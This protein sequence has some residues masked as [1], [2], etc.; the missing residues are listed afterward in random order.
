M[1]ERRPGA[2]EGLVRE[3]GTDETEAGE[4]A[5]GERGTRE[6]EE[7]GWTGGRAGEGDATEERIGGRREAL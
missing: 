5:G 6:R 7:S 1:G 4:R 2:K 3:S